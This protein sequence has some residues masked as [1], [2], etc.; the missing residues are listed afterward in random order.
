M[1][2]GYGK[3]SGCKGCDTSCG[4]PFGK[5]C[6]IYKYIKTGGIKNYEMFKEQLISEFNALNI[7]GMPEITELYALNSAFVNLAYPMPNGY[8]LKLLND[9]EI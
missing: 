2:C 9:N 7:E 4:C 5:Q 6:F 3:N 1:N 8:E